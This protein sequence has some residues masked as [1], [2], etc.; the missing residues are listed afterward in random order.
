MAALLSVFA[1][2][3][4]AAGEGEAL[5]GACTACHGPEGRSVSGL[6]TLAGMDRRRFMDRMQAFR[7]GEG[8]IMNRIAPA[9]DEAQTAALADHF[10]ALDRVDDDRRHAP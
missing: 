4:L 3:V 7:N 9:Y 8:T 5:A 2:A 10:A 6:P 1:S